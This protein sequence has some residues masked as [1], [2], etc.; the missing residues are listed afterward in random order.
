MKTETYKL[1]SSW[2]AYLT[3]GDDTIVLEEGTKE[4]ADA[5]IAS[6][7]TLTCIDFDD[8]DGDFYTYTFSAE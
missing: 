2:V 6:H 1:P 3:C 8:L 5:W 4:A 7:P